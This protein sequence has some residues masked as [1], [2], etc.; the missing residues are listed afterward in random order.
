[1]HQININHNLLI[2]LFDEPKCTEFIK[3]TA[4]YGF[5]EGNLANLYVQMDVVLTITTTELFKTLILYHLKNVSHKASCFYQTMNQFAPTAWQ[6]LKPPAG[7]CLNLR[8]L[9]DSACGDV[10]TRISLFLEVFFFLSGIV[11]CNKYN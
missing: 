6:K 2:N 7:S 8:R 1:L 9:G 11:C 10:I 4:K 5:N 3:S